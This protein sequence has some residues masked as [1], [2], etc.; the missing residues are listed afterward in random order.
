MTEPADKTWRRSYSSFASLGLPEDLDYRLGEPP[1]E[2]LLTA[3]KIPTYIPV[4]HE[5][6]VD[7]GGHTC[8]ATCPPPYVP[9]PVPLARRAR[10]RLRR[11]RHR[12][13]RVGGLR[14]VHK[15]RI[16]R[17]DG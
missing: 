9:P 15:D 1:G 10:L 12:L 8:D 14:L 17:D 4:T 3:H 16:D 11:A 6:L 13:A 5:L 2:A 7:S